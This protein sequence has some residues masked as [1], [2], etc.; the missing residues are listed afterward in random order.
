MDK[1]NKLFRSVAMDRLSSPEQLDQ[2]L[3][4]TTP[5]GWLALLTLGGLIIVALIWGVFGSIPTKVQGTG[6]FISGEGVKDISAPVDGEVTIVYVSPGDMVSRGQMVARIAQ[7][8]LITEI[9]QT[10]T[11]ISEIENIK[12]QTRSFIQNEMALQA[13]HNTREINRIDR[14]IANLE[15]QMESL[16]ERKE[17][18]EMLLQEGLI[19]R[20]Q[21]LSTRDKI[22]SLEQK[23][24]QLSNEKMQLPLRTLQ[25]QEEQEQRVR[26]LE[27][28][29]SDVKRELQAL[30]E[31][32]EESSKVYSPHSGYILEVPVTEGTLISPGTRI[33]SLELAGE[34]VEELVGVLYVSAEK[35]KLVQPG[36]QA[37]LTPTTVR[38]EEDGSML[39]LVTSAGDFP[40]TR[41]NMMRTIRNE[42][43]VE[44]L[45]AAG[46]PIEVLV[47]P[48]P[49]PD[50]FSGYKWTSAG[51]PRQTIHSGT[52]TL[53][54][55]IVDDQA[56][57]TLVIPWLKKNILGHGQVYD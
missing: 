46:S 19:T 31:R 10:R 50:T 32:L 33:A 9:S 34:A 39:G 48:I 44:Q 36:M 45:A 13:E 7:P 51:G 47:S 54:S 56:P 17:N 21:F 23:I 11:R 20:H 40:A 43:L 1:K 8:Q 55:V 49:S 30:E 22:K 29:I 38:A 16:H 5:K 4:V 18:Q 27:M 12:E 41:E 52:M 35:G 25:L 26:E 6:I 2:V 57:I 53:G 24:T 3:Q 37:H 14:E 28:Q 15:E 42:L